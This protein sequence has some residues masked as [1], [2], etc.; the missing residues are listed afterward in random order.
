MH[1]YKT[2]MLSVVKE[3]IKIPQN[4]N[5]NMKNTQKQKPTYAKN[6]KRHPMTQDF[7]WITRRNGTVSVREI[8]AITDKQST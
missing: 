8:D 3:M 4:T 6:L 1:K 5:L 7:L 2:R